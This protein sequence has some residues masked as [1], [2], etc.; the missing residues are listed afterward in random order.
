MS[1]ATL[2]CVDGW[3]ARGRWNVNPQPGWGLPVAKPRG[4]RCILLAPTFGVATQNTNTCGSCWVQ[5]EVQLVF[6][7]GCG[8]GPA[9]KGK[10]K[11]HPLLSQSRSA[12]KCAKRRK[13]DASE[14]KLS[15]ADFG[16][17][18]KVGWRVELSQLSQKGKAPM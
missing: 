3:S 10:Q 2:G 17:S 16:R 6:M 18:F 5:L 9:P 7:G 13:Y 15:G 14:R 8:G 1:N 12:K 11:T 4:H